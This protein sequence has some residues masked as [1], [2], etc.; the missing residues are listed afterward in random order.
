VHA[1]T[2]PGR[3]FD[4]HVLIGSRADLSPE[5]VAPPDPELAAPLGKIRKTWRHPAVPAGTPVFTDDHAPIE[6][7]T[8]RMIVRRAFA[9]FRGARD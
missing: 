4:N 6:F 3:R 7:F 5:G 1:F 2:I 9:A 8:E